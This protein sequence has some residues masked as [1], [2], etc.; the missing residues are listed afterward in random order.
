MALSWGHMRSIEDGR[1]PN[2]GG[3]AARLR[4]AIVEDRD[5][6]RFSLSALLDEAP[7]FRCVAAWSTM[8]A[9]LREM[10]PPLPD[11]VL[12]DINL[13]GIDGIEGMRRQ[14]SSRA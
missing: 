4:V 5:E 8:E 2:P 7:G 11:V 9:A 12:V 3:K 1:D 10:A 13:P 14:S 6:I